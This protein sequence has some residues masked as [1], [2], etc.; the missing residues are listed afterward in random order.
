MKIKHL[1]LS[2]I[3]VATALVSCQKDLTKETA[4][5]SLSVAEVN[6]ESTK[7]DTK[8]ITLSSTRTWI[9][10]I[11]AAA[12]EWVSVSPA[13]GEASADPQTIEI[14][15]KDN[16]GFNR[17][18]DITFKIRG[19]SRILKVNQNGDKGN[20]EA[21]VV[22]HNDFDKGAAEQ[23]A[24]KKWPF[25]DATE[26]WKNQTGS[27]I[28]NVEYASKSVSC[29]NNSNT[30]SNYSLYPGSGLNNLFFGPAGNYLKIS[31]IAVDPSE[32]NYC[33]SF[34]T[35]KYLKDADD[36]KV[37][38]D[39]LAVYVGDGSKWAQLKNFTFASGNVPD[40]QWDLV[41]IDITLPENTTS[42]SL[43]FSAS[44]ASAYR[45]DDLDLSIAENEGTPVEFTVSLP[46]E[47]EPQ[48]GEVTGLVVALT[49]KSIVIKTSDGYAYAYSDNGISGVAIGD[50]VKV[51]GEQGTFAGINQIKNPE[52]E[53]LSDGNEV[54]YPD[55]TVIGSDD[56][57]AFSE[58]FAYIKLTGILSISSSD[59][60]TY[61]NITVPGSDKQGSL[62]YPTQDVSSLDG[63]LIDVEG[64]F[65]GW[66]GSGKYF[67]IA[68]V[69][70]AASSAKYF[71]VE[72]N[73]IGVDATATSATIKVSSNVAWSVSSE[74]EGF[75][76][77]PASGENNGEVTVS[78]DANTDT[79]NTRTAIIKITTNDAE[80][81]EAD[82]TKT[83][84]IIQGKAMS[85]NAQVIVLSAT[86]DIAKITGFP[87]AKKV[88]YS[89]YEINGYTWGFAGSSGNGY[90]YASKNE[91]VIWGK[92]GAYVKMPAIE[93][94]TLTKVTILTGA[95]ASTSVEVGVYTKEDVVVSGG[96]DIQ[97]N[98]Q[99]AEFSWNLAGTASN[100]AYR[101][102][103]TS[104]HNAQ[105]QKLTLVYE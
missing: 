27:G 75:T 34:G 24:N 85:A 10:E 95:S 105:F 15:V 30:D 50:E 91:V 12:K 28:T 26:I 32:R 1:L 92:S 98:Q 97:L 59:K 19:G 2:A 86:E 11:P 16:G 58:A 57:A 78:F 4:S 71:T 22:Y 56:I 102:K 8:T 93:G 43:Y 37:S 35:E 79:E 47:S 83:V 76:V 72:N 6:F 87:T 82:R 61:Y 65:V 52:I 81:A 51:T 46:G 74:T 94:K 33:L 9:A 5:I 70:I 103:V 31:N 64:Y 38:F 25:C 41:S 73:E 80:I 53:T 45:I 3:A 40:G 14:T 49:A 100:T 7:T 48:T 29:R 88:D 21:A 36:N 104:K 99:N 60:G 90:Y 42:L 17:S 67:N 101:L 77:N 63:K 13:Q 96:A 20:K 39:E 18:A 69:N 68:M 44:V 84:T 66:T 23:D 62:A 55:P 89:E 54:T